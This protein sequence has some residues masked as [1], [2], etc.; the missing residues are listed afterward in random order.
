MRH[1][2]LKPALLAALAFSFL[3]MLDS[4]LDAGC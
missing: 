3:G 2:L 4:R 1:S